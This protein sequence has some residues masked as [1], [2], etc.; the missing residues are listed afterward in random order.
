MPQQASSPQFST[1]QN[2]AAQACALLKTL[3]NQ[4][5]LLLLCQLTQG[6]HSVSELES[7]VGIA[8]PSLSQQLG[9]LRGEQLVRT[10]RAGKQIYYQIASPQAQA[11]MQVLYELFCGANQGDGQ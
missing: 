1:M 11:I 3:A 6:E 2:A 4:D 5:R 9:V 10:R 7:A 8:Q